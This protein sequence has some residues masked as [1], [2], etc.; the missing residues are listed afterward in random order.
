M[1][2]YKEDL[3]RVEEDAGKER[4]IAEG[5]YGRKQIQELIQ[6]A[7][8]ALQRAPGRAQVTLTADTL[9]VAN[10]GKPF[11]ES[12]LRA[13][14]YTHLSNKTGTEIGRFGLGFKSISGISDNP[15]IFSR[16]V[17]FEFHRNQTATSLSE[18]L[19]RHFDPDDVPA[20]RLAWPLSPAVE[21]QGDP[22][23][24]EL[25]RWAITVIK[26]PLK[27]GAAEQLSEEIKEFDESFNL[28]APH[29][30]VL[31]LVDEL[32]GNERHFKASKRG[33]RVTLTTEGGD[34]QYLVVS[35]EHQPSERALESA[36]HAARRDSV[37]VSWALPLTGRV[38]IGQLS[39]Y[40]P[41]KSETTLSGRL[42]APW[43][44]SDDRINVIECA[45][46]EELLVDVVPQLVAGARKELVG[47]GAFGRYIDVLPARG[48]EARSWADRVLNEPVF[49]TLR[50]KRCLPDLDGQLRSPSV[51]RRIPELTTELA[52]RW[53][54]VTGNRSEWV[55]PDCT[56]SNERRS[57]VDR[58]M[59]DSDR[60]RAT[61]GRV[62]HWLQSVVAQPGAD[63]SAA[64]IELAAQLSGQ[65]GVNRD[66]N[67]RNAEQDIRDSR[68]VLL[69]NGT[70]AQP[71]RGR[72]FLRTNPTQSGT[73][74]V[75]AGVAGRPS[76]EAALKDLGVTPF[77]DGGEM[78]QLLTQLRQ[79]GTVDWD[80]LWMAMRGSGLQQVQEAFD[81]VLE[82]RAAQIVC[83][84]NGHGRW[85]LPGSLYVPGDCLRQIREDGDYLVDGNYHAADHPILYLLGLRSRPT[86][87]RRSVP[88]KWLSKYRRTVHDDIGDALTL[89]Q[90]ARENI[91]IQTIDNLLGP[92][93]CLPNLSV[94]NRVA[95][96]TAV[97]NEI[98]VPR[99]GVSHPSVRKS[100]QYVAP[101][102]WWVRLAGMLP[103]TLGPMPVSEAFVPE[104]PG[105]PTGLVPSVTQVVLTTDME[106]VLNLK[107]DIGDLDE[108]AFG[109]LVETHVARNDVERVGQTYAW[110]CWTLRT[111]APPERLWVHCRGK[112]EEVQ[113]S[114]VAVVHGI[115]ESR[116]LDEFGIPCVVV[117]AA[118]DVHT[119][120]EFWD[121]LEGRELPIAYSYETSA[122]PEVLTDVFPVLNILETVDDLDG[123]KLQKCLSISKVAA[124]PGQPEM[125]VDCLAGIEGQHI[126]V[127]GSS[128]AAILKQVLGQLLCDDSDQQVAMLMDTLQR[129][130]NSKRIR[131]IR[132]ASTDAERLLMLAGED[133]LQ[134]LIPKSAL[135]YLENEGSVEPHGMELAQLCITMLGVRAL[136]R[137]SKIDSDKLPDDVPSTWAG[138]YN[139]RKWV[140]S[141]GFGEEWAGQRGGR[142]NKPTEFVDGPTQLDALHDYQQE[143]S[144]RL[145]R[146][147]T[148]NG[149]RR[150]IVSLPTGAGKTRVTVQTIIECIRDGQ[151]DGPQ[152]GPFAGPILWLADGEELCEQAIDTWS[153]LWR[154]VG[155]QDTQL[156]LSRFWSNYEMEEESGGVQVVV[157]TWQKIKQRAVGNES[158]A[159][160]AEAPIAIIDEA[161]G[162]YTPSYTSILEWLQR[163]TRQRDQPLIGLTAT[164]FRGRRDSEETERLLRRFDDNRLDE[165]VFGDE[166]P[167]VRLQ[168]D[169]V[170]AHARLEIIDGISID[171]ADHELEEFR[172][173]GWLSKS[174]EARLGRDE[175]RTRTIVESILKKPADWQIVVFA[176][177][178]ENAQTLATLLTLS[179]RS[180]ASIDQDTSP[181]DRRAAIE[182]FKAGD[183]KV[184]TNYAV[185]SQGFDAPKTD[186]VYITRPTSSEVRYQQMVGR[187]LRGPKNGGTEEVLIVNMLD[188]IIEF[189]HSIVYQSIQDIV[190]SEGGEFENA[191]AQTVGE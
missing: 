137:A 43:K 83:V 155:R 182:R 26:I 114:Q 141:L 172:S 144:L 35:K 168:R 148:G 38:E 33:N 99:V 75:D 87:S 158:F 6:N 166:H 40:F 92:L 154:A 104:V 103:T 133:R 111:D 95:L 157:A 57:K 5:G 72:C 97:I 70:L 136:E 173:K 62:Q 51:V 126:L 124:V 80:E 36:G 186:A 164:P 149:L 189:G 135:T 42:N 187:G 170:L 116:V 117:G 161:H 129:R 150:G 47:N 11:E 76:T 2:V 54:E 20:L 71:V 165:G 176:A 81:G 7:A 138:S 49:A 180:A 63:Q 127:T 53:L 15:Q 1:R 128:E 89:S 56:T 181:E 143:V 142:R 100:G 32:G 185:L 44:L 191:L 188:N 105:I 123:L 130:R 183:L 22:V 27:E 171:L 94:T 55:H 28:F 152:D 8:D 34:R 52:G 118:E 37:T 67:A 29:V 190:D 4:G 59:Q 48:K 113:T 93:E 98:E 146:L 102:I 79:T 41:V 91:Q 24:A 163:G 77:E 159:W 84:R 78:L 107:K 147:L 125:R 169:R 167:Q 184:L 17:S 153:Y 9:Y 119:L 65:L 112:W 160:L 73:S 122:D 110:W 131:E 46:N 108:R 121:C 101:E 68:I 156:I 66:P 58:L 31:D 145:K 120:S 82:G 19:G 16:S 134:A 151:L 86:R 64:A 10:E 61:Q 25:G 12:G 162:A 106:T 50:E 74:F 109:A 96:S 115:D 39:A 21:F 177:S 23:L 14:L 174:A 60:P 13:L 69:E 178:V 3:N 140:K 179:G 88:E 85:V 175:D 45:F 90:S 30:R 18:E 139:T 132:G